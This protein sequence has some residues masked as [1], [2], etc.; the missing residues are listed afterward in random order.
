LTVFPSNRI[1]RP[2]MDGLN[3]VYHPTKYDWRNIET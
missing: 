1:V 3:M 2:K